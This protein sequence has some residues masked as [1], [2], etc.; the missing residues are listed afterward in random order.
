MGTSLSTETSEIR[1]NYDKKKSEYKVYGY[2]HRIQKASKIANTPPLILFICLQF[3]ME[4]DGF[5]TIS[6][7][8][9]LTDYCKTITK[10]NDY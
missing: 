7:H 2:V 1:K 8:V 4:C 6:P 5:S 9:S 3:A 10:T